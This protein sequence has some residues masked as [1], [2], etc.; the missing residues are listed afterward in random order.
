MNHR[1]NDSRA[2]GNKKFRGKSMGQAD[3]FYYHEALRYFQEAYEKQ[4]Q[5]DL[6]KAIE[7]YQKSLEL[8]P[9]A[10]AYTFLGWAYSFQGRFEDAINECKKA[11]QFDPEYGNPYNDIGS[12]LIE[13]GRYDEAI[14]WLEKA[15]QAPRYES[16]CY[17][18]YNLGRVW[19][20]KGNW[21]RAIDCYQNSLKEN[22]EYSLAR[23][24]LSRLQ[25]M[26]N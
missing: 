14:E 17:P 24:A 25:G 15:I 12:Y 26:L 4:T 5:G 7:L 23:K 20:K 2:T 9:T 11:I 6:P 8:Q 13:T 19:E 3:S 1:F 16:Y 21:F 18:H 22:S 10:E